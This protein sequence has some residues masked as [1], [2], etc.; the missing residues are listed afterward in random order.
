MDNSSPKI[1]R[2]FLQKVIEETRVGKESSNSIPQIFCGD[3]DMRIARDGTWYYKGSPIERYKL[4][5]LFASILTRDEKGHF[6]LKTKVERCRVTVDDAP[7]LAVEMNVDR[8]KNKQQLIFRTNVDDIVI[9]GPKHS[10]IVRVDPETNEPSPYL[11][12]RSGIEALITRSVFYDLVELG[13]K[14][15]HES[16]LILGVWS[17][18]IFFHLGSID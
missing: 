4:V 13:I 12:I 14:T 8:K 3:I 18:G 10:I 5:K 6:W 1:S 7:F 15:I 11:E 17:D 9:A 16:H 2:G